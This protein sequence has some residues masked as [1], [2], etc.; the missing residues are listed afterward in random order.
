MSATQR[1]DSSLTTETKLANQSPEK[2]PETETEVAASIRSLQ[3]E[4]QQVSE[5]LE[6]EKGYSSEV[7]TQ[8]KQIIGP[9]NESYHVRP[10]SVSKYDSS[11]S[12]VVLTP[13]GVVC[14]FHNNGTVVS[15]PLE[16]VQSEVL[17][18][19]LGE[20]IPEVNVLVKKRRQNISARVMSLERLAKEMRK[21]PVIP[22]RSGHN[23]QP[24]QAS[25]NS[26]EKQESL[27][28]MKSAVQK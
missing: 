4:Y 11:I 8:F 28:A 26:K 17:V 13:Q 22:G 27:D 15:R 21:I 12:D 9:L 1:V 6:I 23:S 24:E 18:K 10:D 14:V 25:G 16:S 7:V 2:K 3:E 5:L 19:V 20:V